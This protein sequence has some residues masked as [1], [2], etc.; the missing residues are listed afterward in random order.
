MRAL[1]FSKSLVL[2]LLAAPLTATSQDGYLL[3][4]GWRVTPAGQRVLLTDLPLNIRCTPD[5]KHAR[6]LS[7]GPVLRRKERRSVFVDGFGQRWQQVVC[8]GRRSLR[9]G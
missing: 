5:G 4:N 8:L 9:Q 3:P 6:R 1:I 2:F 7:H